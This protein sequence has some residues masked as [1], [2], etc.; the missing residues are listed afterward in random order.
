MALRES[1]Q[2]VGVNIL[3]APFVHHSGRDVPGSD[4]VAQHWAG[5]GSIS[6]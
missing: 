6:L 3:G 5:Y 4:E 1:A 2:I